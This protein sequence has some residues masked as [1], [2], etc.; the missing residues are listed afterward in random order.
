[1]LAI[2]FQRFSW[3]AFST[4]CRFKVVVAILKWVNSINSIFKV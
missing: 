4:D 3:I 1:M 2:A